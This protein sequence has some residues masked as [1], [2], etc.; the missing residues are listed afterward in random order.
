M[1]EIL[2]S[3]YSRTKWKYVGCYRDDRCYHLS[4]FACLITAGRS[5]GWQAGLSLW[6]PVT[7]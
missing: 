3:C 5:E 1:S 2:L 7:M 6:L 4:R